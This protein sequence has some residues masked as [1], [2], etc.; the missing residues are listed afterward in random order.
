MIAFER[1]IWI[2]LFLF[3][4]PLILLLVGKILNFPTKMERRFH[5]YA[6]S[7]GL[8]ASSNK[9]IIR[10]NNLIIRYTTRNYSLHTRLYKLQISLPAFENFVFQIS[11]NR[12]YFDIINYKKLTNTGSDIN[13]SV[14]NDP[15]DFKYSNTEE[16]IKSFFAINVCYTPLAI[17]DG[18]RIHVIM[19]TLRFEE[20]VISVIDIAYDFVIR[21]KMLIEEH[22][23]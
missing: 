22:S 8:T 5:T 20:P 13:I 2:V 16:L 7:L 12:S 6:K 3:G 1:E 15:E 9:K 21:N 10:D 11:W 18:K 4:T 23:K 19:H 14:I 17:S